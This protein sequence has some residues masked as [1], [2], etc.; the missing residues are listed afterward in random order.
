M[1]LASVINEKKR[2]HETGDTHAGLGLLL[3]IFRCVMLVVTVVL[4]VCVGGWVSG[5]ARPRRGGPGICTVDLRARCFLNLF[6]CFL[7][8]LFLSSSHKAERR[9]GV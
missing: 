1:H 5:W 3:R 7:L 9:V 4:C 2:S 6:P 8:S